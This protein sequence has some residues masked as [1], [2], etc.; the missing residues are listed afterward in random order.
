M[1]FGGSDEDDNLQLLC[2]RCNMAK[3]QAE[4]RGVRLLDP[5][6]FDPEETRKLKLSG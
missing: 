6:N 2:V 5:S 1:A 4:S 3:A